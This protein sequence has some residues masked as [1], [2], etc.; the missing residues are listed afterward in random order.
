MPMEEKKRQESPRPSEEKK[1][2]FTLPE[3]KK[4]MRLAHRVLH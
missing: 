4:R 2:L 1:A 3:K